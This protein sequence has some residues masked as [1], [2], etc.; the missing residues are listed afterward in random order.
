MT[1]SKVGKDSE[2][3]TGPLP[4]TG[5][6]MEK[7]SV[8]VTGSSNTDS[9]L[10]SKGVMDALRTAQV[11]IASA[12]TKQMQ[13]LKLREMQYKQ[14]LLSSA[15]SVVPKLP[16]LLSDNSVARWFEDVCYNLKASPWNIDDTSIYDLHNSELDP[17]EEV[18]MEYK[19]RNKQLSKHLYK[20]LRE[21]KKD[22]LVDELRETY[23]KNDGIALLNAVYKGLLPK[24][25]AQILQLL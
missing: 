25:A 5:T 8:P 12:S 10:T 21:A 14:I 2:P 16:E 7:P 11:K 18:N 19:I 24:H 13:E 4:M 22:D 20:R 17:K 15:D 6:K 3:V 9:P 1:G 23:S